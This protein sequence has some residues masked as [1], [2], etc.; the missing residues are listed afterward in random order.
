MCARTSSGTRN[1]AF[2]SQPSACFVAATSASPSGE[3]C[4]ELVPAFFGEP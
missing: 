3:P 4:A 1:F 2:G